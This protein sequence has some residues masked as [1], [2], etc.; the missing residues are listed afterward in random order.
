M[1]GVMANPDADS[2]SVEPAPP[3][4]EPALDSTA[5][6]L[7]RVR[8]GDSAAR[9]RLFE[10][11]LPLLTRWAHRRLPARARDLAE[12]DDLVQVALSRALARVGEFEARREGAFLA[13]LRTILMNLVRDHVRHSRARQTEALEN[14]IVDRAPSPLERTVNRDVLDRYE[15]ALKR[16]EDDTQQAV[17]LRVEFGYSYAEIATALG[18]PTANAARMLVGRALVELARSMRDG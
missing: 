10:R 8:A 13:Y 16:L 5:Y 6:L 14:T 9:E 1:L 4:G 18:K 17:M 12:T 11:V 3:P 15:R 7:E 2:D